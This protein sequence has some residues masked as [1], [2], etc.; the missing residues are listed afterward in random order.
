MD[1]NNSSRYIDD[2][3]DAVMSY[4]NSK[5]LLTGLAPSEVNEDNEVDTILRIHDKQEKKNSRLKLK[6]AFK[7][8]IGD[9]VRVRQI[10]TKFSRA[11]HESFSLEIFKIRSCVM[12]QNFP[13]YKL[14][15]MNNTQI[16]G[17]F[18]E[19]QLCAAKESDD[20]YYRIEKI[21]R[22]R[23]VNN[24]TEVLVKWYGWPKQFA[25][26]IKESDIKD[27]AQN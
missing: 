9:S 3:K 4:N 26:W 13:L 21:L 5:K 14:T 2:L 10:K 11:F 18:Y 19:P 8:S 17:L 24:V 6:R 12:K 23:K 1:E 15:D 20:Q 27:T 25:S 22:R 7:Y 16:K